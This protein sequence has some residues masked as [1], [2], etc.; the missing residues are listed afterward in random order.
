[1]LIDGWMLTNERRES[2]SEY[3][4]AR[5]YAGE[6]AGGRRSARDTKSSFSFLLQAASRIIAKWANFF[7]GGGIFGGGRKEATIC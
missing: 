7:G 5:E 6:Y 2:S 4:E 3:G 1:M